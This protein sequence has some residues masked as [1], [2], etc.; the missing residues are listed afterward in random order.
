MAN[1]YHVNKLLFLSINIFLYKCE[2][3]CLCTNQQNWNVERFIRALSNGQP[4]RKRNHFSVL[5]KTVL[6]KTFS[7]PLH[8]QVSVTHNRVPQS[9]PVDILSQITIVRLSSA[10][11]KLK[12]LPWPVP[13]DTRSTLFP[14]TAN[15]VSRYHQIS[16][17][18]GGLPKSPTP[19]WEPSI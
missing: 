16:P 5:S 13:L 15:D 7:D 11:Q 8:L 4:V 19:S 6:F 3:V 9:S 18:E 17:Q 12:K 2:P 1:D 14:M 10:L